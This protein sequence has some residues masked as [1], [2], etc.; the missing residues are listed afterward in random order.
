LLSLEVSELI[1]V[2]NLVFIRDKAWLKWITVSAKGDWGA[3]NSVVVSS[4]LIDRA[5]F[6]GDFV[7][8]HPLEST[9]WLSSMATIILSLA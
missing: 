8:V 6:I 7:V 9:K 3:L 1:N 2:V 5:S 4:S